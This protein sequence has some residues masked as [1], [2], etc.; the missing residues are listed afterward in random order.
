MADKKIA[1]IGLG[2]LGSA[3]AK[4]LAKRGIEV[5]AIDRNEHFIDEIADSVAV[6]VALD[7]TE[8][9]AL[10][11][12]DIQSF[13]AVVVAIG[14]DFEQLLLTTTLLMDLGVKRIMARAR[15]K[16][17]QLILQKI[18]INEVFLPEEEVGINVAEHL[19]NPSIVSFL[20]LP[21]NFCIMEIHAP[22]GIIGQS[23]AEIKMRRLHSINLVTTMKSRKNSHKTISGIPTGDTIIEKED[24]LVLF[25]KRTNI[26]RFIETNQR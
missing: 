20:D 23:L 12:V 4:K 25:G 8:K 18:G 24:V 2:Q 5:L 17:Q 3:I 15:G 19:I 7:A 10:L 11:S 22:E 13:D 16:N 14:E 1:V 6:A 21:E 9:K 26:E